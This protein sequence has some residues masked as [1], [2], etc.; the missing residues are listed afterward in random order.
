MV[1]YSNKFLYKFLILIISMLNCAYYKYM[2][3]NKKLK[4]SILM[5]RI[6]SLLIATL[7]TICMATPA[8]AT[9]K[10]QN[11]N[12][13]ND[14]ITPQA[15]VIYWFRLAEN[16]SGD[17]HDA[18]S[19]E[20]NGLIPLRRI[21]A[22]CAFKFADGIERTVVVQIGSK[23]FN[24]IADG[25]VHQVGNWMASTETPLIISITNVPS[26]CSSVV[27]VYSIS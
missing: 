12:Y 15:D 27:S 21:Y 3:E 24:V 16:R 1:K 20:Q 6:M 22:N 10:E 14:E 7:L 26:I 9:C 5:K 25:N 8:Y 23:T 4:E 13:N 19:V 2:L 11:I 18:F 17:Y